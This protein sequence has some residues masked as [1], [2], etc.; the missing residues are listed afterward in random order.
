MPKRLALAVGFGGSP[1]ENK[2]ILEKVKVAEEVGVEAVFSAETWGRDQFSLLTQIAL[3]TS[4]IKIGTGIA[5]VYGRSPAVLAMTAATLDELSGGRMILGLGTSGALVIEHWHGQPFEKPLQRLKEYAEIINKIVAGE[6]V[7]HDGEIFKLGVGRKSNFKL[8][9][10]PLRNHIPIYIASISPKSIKQVGEVADGW[11]PIYWP[12]NR[13]KEGMTLVHEGERETGRA[14]GS[15]E[16]VPSVTLV[17]EPDPEKARA[18]AAGPISFYITRMGVFYS[19][20]LT[21]N[22]YGEQVQKAQEAWASKDQAGT[23]AAITDDMLS[24]TAIYGSLEDCKIQLEERYQA[25]VDMPIVAMPQGGP[26]DVEKVIGT[27]IN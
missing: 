12:M 27:L 25:G 23:L 19:R 8:L 17:V 9:F 24:E 7:F 14:A 26:R 21:R 20:M 6:E 1:E 11:M 22:G 3:Q 15:V 10:K 5:P 2:A 16:L 18:M 4:R 13:F